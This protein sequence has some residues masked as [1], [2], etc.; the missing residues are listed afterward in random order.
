MPTEKEFYS[1]LLRQLLMLT[2]TALI[3]DFGQTMRLFALSMALYWTAVFLGIC[4]HRNSRFFFRYGIYAIQVCL[5]ND[6]DVGGRHGSDVAEG[7]DHVVLVHLGGGD[8]PRD[9]LAE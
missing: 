9:D 4:L 5:G 7:V 3:L 2:V 6:E 8:V 1:Q